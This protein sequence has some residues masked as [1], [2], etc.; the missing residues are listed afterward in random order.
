MIGT[1]LSVSLFFRKL[2]LVVLISLLVNAVFISQV[3]ADE[4][5]PDDIR[6]MLE[7]LYGANKKE[8]PSPRYKQDLNKDGFTDWVAIKKGCKLKN[9]CPAEVFICISDK[10]GLCSE[11]C[12]SEV[13]TLKGIEENIKDIKCE[14]TC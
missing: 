7:D 4:K 2:S 9:N 12:Y 14:S 11:Y 3:D 8:W 1:V 10:K 5:M 6:Y 13:R